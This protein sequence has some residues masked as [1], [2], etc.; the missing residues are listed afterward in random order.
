M[1]RAEL[2]SRPEESAID[3]SAPPE[4]AG[5]CTTPG[6]FPGR[7]GDCKNVSGVWFGGF[8]PGGLAEADVDVLEALMLFGLGVGGVGTLVCGGEFGVVGERGEQAA[9]P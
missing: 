4:S 2:M 5:A 6:P 1:T 7:W 9:R 3:G 8:G